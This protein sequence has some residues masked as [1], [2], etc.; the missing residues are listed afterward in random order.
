[1][2]L[3]QPRAGVVATG[4]RIAERSAQ[5]LEDRRAEEEGTQ[6]GR[7]LSEQLLEILADLTIVACEALEKGLPVGMRPQRQARELEP[8]RPA[9]GTGLKRSSSA[10]ISVTSPAARRPA[11]GSGGSARLAIASCSVLGRWRSRYLTE[12]W[13]SSLCTRW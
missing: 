4:H 5:P 13:I 12:V 1:V 9:L 7:L 10:R 11:S 6:R 3:F 8:G 2:Y